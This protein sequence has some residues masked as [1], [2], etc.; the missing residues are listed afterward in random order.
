M[1]RFYSLAFAL[2]AIVV[3]ASAQSHYLHVATESGW[4]VIDLDKA[5]RLTF[6]NGTMTV[7]DARQNVIATF[8]QAQLDMMYVN[9]ET[10]VETICSDAAAEPSFTIAGDGHTINILSGGVFEVY[11]LDGEKIIEINGVKADQ[12][13]NLSPLSKGIYIIRLNDYAVKYSIR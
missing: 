10:G 1:K 6:K 12:T 3:G 7:T 11:A 13:V 4:E 5:D 8:P 2:L 9:D